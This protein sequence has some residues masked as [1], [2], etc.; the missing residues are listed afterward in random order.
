ME[1][2]LLTSMLEPAARVVLVGGEERGSWLLEQGYASD[3]AF[4]FAVVLTQEAAGAAGRITFTDQREAAGQ[5]CPELSAW[6]AALAE[7]TPLAWRGGGGGWSVTW[8]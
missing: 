6:A 3:R 1:Q 7:R 8:S 5:A 4:A 2:A